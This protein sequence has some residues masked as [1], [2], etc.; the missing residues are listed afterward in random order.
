M[1]E[2]SDANNFWFCT[3]CRKAWMKVQIS[4]LTQFTPPTWSIQ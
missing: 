2:V 4:Q 1:L 3:A